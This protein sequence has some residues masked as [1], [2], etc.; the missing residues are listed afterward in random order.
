MLRSGC[1]ERSVKILICALWIL[2]PVLQTVIAVAMLH[3]GQHR[4][5]KWFFAYIVAQIPIFAV[6]FPTFWYKFS[7]YFFVSWSTTAIS[8]ALGFKVIYEAFVDVF[9]PSQTLRDLGTLLLKWGALMMLLVAGV[10][11]VSMR[12]S[13]VGL[14]TRT[15]L[16]LEG[17]VRIVQVA[18]V[19]FLLFSAARMGISRNRHGFGIALGFGLFAVVEMAEITS[20]VGFRLSDVSMGIVNLVGYNCALLIWLGYTLAKSS[21][22]EA[23]STLLQPQR[24]EQSFSTIQYPAQADSLIP[25]FEAMVD[26]AIS[27]AQTTAV[28][29]YLQRI[30]PA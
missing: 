21:A 5:Y 20:S 25:T 4:A 30:E 7:V 2:H 26:R 10:M 24:W 11:S 23:E 17:C 9:Q 16:T 8:M 13:D 14:W 18:M 22:P 15:V 19:L 1:H 3:R 12:L 29:G 6:C 28:S 27:R